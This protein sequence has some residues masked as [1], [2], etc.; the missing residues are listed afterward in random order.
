MKANDI[1]IKDPYKLE[2]KFY[3]DL[4]KQFADVTIMDAKY[5]SGHFT[6]IEGIFFERI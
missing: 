4:K 3:D 1:F 2:K 6:G 5:S